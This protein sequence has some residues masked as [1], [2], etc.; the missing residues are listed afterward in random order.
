MDAL[1]AVAAF[2]GVKFD[3][4]PLEQGN[5]QIDGSIAAL[6]TL[7][8]ALA[9]SAIVVGIRNFVDSYSEA[10]S[11]INDAA[12]Q[13][14][15]GTQALQEL[16]FAASQSGVRVEQMNV[17]LSQL[18]ARAAEAR[19]GSGAAAAAFHAL[20]IRATDAHGQVRPVSDL[21]DDIATGMMRIENPAQRVRIATDLFG[22]AGRRLVGVLHQGEGGLAEL[23]AQVQA[24]GGGMSEEGIAAAD[25]YGDAM[26]RWNVAMMSIK[27]TV[28]VFLLPKL[29]AITDMVSKVVAAITKFTHGTN[30]V[31]AAVVAASIALAVRYLPV[32]RNAIT[33]VT[34]FTRAQALSMLGFVALVLIV[35]DLIA[36]FSGGH[37]V[38]GEFIDAMLGAGAAENVVVSL[39]EAW[40]DLIDTIREA[41]DL[42]PWNDIQGHT[43]ARS[44]RGFR[45]HPGAA[46]VE[47]RSGRTSDPRSRSF[48]SG[49][50]PTPRVTATTAAESSGRTSA[51]NTRAFVPRPA[52]NVSVTTTDNSRHVYQIDGNRDAAAI[53]RA[54]ERRRDQQR[55][56]AADAAHPIPQ[57]EQ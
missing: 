56:A 13:I 55:R 43:S 54:I 30:L 24:L 4:R 42:L 19:T 11:D 23:R 28:A 31:Q 14:G 20:G 50:N 46:P 51:P 49:I 1:R 36:L 7:G 53:A 18:S 26:G 44:E 34:N 57:R 40:Q 16:Q 33:A 37:S 41:R 3:A 22:G 27:T 21:M 9:S 39:R 15:I 6:K 29:Q 38:I 8:A 47:S 32:I 5:K 52:G 35:D 17:A 10:G 48:R 25:A 45:G 12:D 2:F